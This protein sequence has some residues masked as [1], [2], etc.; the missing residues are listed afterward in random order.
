[1]NDANAIFARNLRDCLAVRGWDQQTF[2]K[3]M[4]VSVSSVSQ[5]MRGIKMPRMPKIDLMC[6]LFNCSRSAL[7][8]RQDPDDE[9]GDMYATLV[10]LASGMKKED[11]MAEIARM[12]WILKSYEDGEK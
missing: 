2:A 8:E 1:M 4:N 5:W 11:I 12:R 7:L 9:R 10:S 3:Y 6:Q